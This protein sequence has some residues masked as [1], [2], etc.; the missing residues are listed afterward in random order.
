LAR[1]PAVETCAPIST[2]RTVCSGFAGHG[3]GLRAS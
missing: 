1:P 3:E 2:S